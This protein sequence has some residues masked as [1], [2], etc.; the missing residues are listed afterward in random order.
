MALEHA[1]VQSSGN[2]HIRPATS[3]TTIGIGDGSQT[4]SLT[5]AELSIFQDGFA[6]IKIGETNAGAIIVN[7]VT[8]L[9][10]LTLVTNST[11]G[12]TNSPDPTIDGQHVILDGDLSPGLSPGTF[13]IVGDVMFAEGSTFSAELSGDPNATTHDLLDVTGRVT[14]G[15]NVTPNV[16]TTNYAA[17]MG[18]IVLIANDQVDAINGTFAGLAEGDAIGDGSS[19]LSISY[20]GDTSND[21]T[22]TATVPTAIMLNNMEVQQAAIVWNILLSILLITLFIAQRHHRH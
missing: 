3:G 5:D 20:M 11:I 19:G 14:I 4:L 12:N 6:N 15:N 1:S 17:G 2:L 22:L 10:E 16:D 18:E 9:D 13:R 21:V 7:T 8:F